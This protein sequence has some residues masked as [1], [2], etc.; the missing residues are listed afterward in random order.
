MW[1]RI[2]D[3]PNSV[4]VDLDKTIKKVAQLEELLNK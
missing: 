3:K 4:R 1:K 2:S